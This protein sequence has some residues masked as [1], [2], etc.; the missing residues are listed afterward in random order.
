LWAGQ[1]LKGKLSQAGEL[2]KDK[3]KLPQACGPDKN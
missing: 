1:R 3:E 2:D